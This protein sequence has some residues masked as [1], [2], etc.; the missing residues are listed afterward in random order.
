[1]KHGA[2]SSNNQPDSKR[3]KR[4]HFIPPPPDKEECFLN[5]AATG[6]IKTFDNLLYS[7]NLNCTNFLNETA[8]MLA[9]AH[10]PEPAKSYL[11]TRLIHLGVDIHVISLWSETA[12]TLAKKR[13]LQDIVDQ[14]DSCNLSHIGLPSE[15]WI[16]ITK[17]LGPNDLDNFRL[18]CKA[19]N[20]LYSKNTDLLWQPLLNRLHAID[21]TISVTPQPGKT[22]RETFIAG[23]NQVNQRQ[24]DD[25]N[26]LHMNDFLE[27]ND[28]QLGFDPS[29]PTTLDILEM[30]QEILVKLNCTIIQKCI[31]DQP[32]EMLSI[33]ESVAISLFPKE[34]LDGKNRAYFASLK[35]IRLTLSPIRTLPDNI[36][37][38][39][40]LEELHCCESSMIKL[41][42]SLSNLKKLRVLCCHSNELTELPEGICELANLIEIDCDTNRIT[43]LPANIGNLVNLRTMD[44]SHNRIS[45]LPESMFYILDNLTVYDFSRNPF[46]DVK[47]NSF[48]DSIENAYFISF[49][50]A[51]PSTLD[52][53]PNR[54]AIDHAQ[55][56]WEP[57]ADELRMVC[58][59]FQYNYNTDQSLRDQY[60]ECF[61]AV[62]QTQL[63]WLS[64]N[65]DPHLLENYDIVRNALTG[66]LSFKFLTLDKMIL[67]HEQMIDFQLTG[68]NELPDLLNVN[69]EDPN[70]SLIFQP[71]DSLDM[72]WSDFELEAMD[73][74]E[75][76]ETTKWKL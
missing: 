9:I 35:S 24:F 20:T 25:L 51:Q 18:V 62:G 23:F 71:N 34:I 67:I 6:D 59:E 65:V 49:I 69:I 68:Q 2:N 73:I 31:D 33:G 58:P 4:T 75:N 44:I 54:K 55:H 29:T 66:E 72:N 15:I 47:E 26:H 7:V 39:E 46:N 8:L 12:L 64:K 1:M 11:V 22:I 36:D 38:C 76:T 41:P 30:R 45:A 42:E 40:N 10:A 32:G 74:D 28:V 52:L 53:A 56:I 5:A 43:Y 3:L 37:V 57:L 19:I 50:H 70:R 48:D 13:N 14:L 17:Y 63:D 60:V 16:E 21:T 27:I 61:K